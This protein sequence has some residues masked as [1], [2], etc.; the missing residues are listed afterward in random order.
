MTQLIRDFKKK[1]TGSA[2]SNM[3]AISHALWD[4]LNHSHLSFFGITYSVYV[5]YFLLM[6]YQLCQINITKQI[7]GG[8]GCGV[9]VSYFGDGRSSSTLSG[10]FRNSPGEMLERTCLYTDLVAFVLYVFI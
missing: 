1:S 10:V 8:Y 9:S 6:W 5:A 4:H 3:A 7:G 2:P